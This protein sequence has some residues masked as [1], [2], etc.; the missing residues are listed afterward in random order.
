MSSP[1]YFLAV[2][3]DPTPPEK[4]TVESGIY[5]PD[6][7]YAPF[8][9][10]R[11]DIVLLY[12]TGS[13]SKYPMQA[14][15]LGIVLHTNDEIVQYRYLPLSQPILKDRIERKFQPSDAEK[16]GNRRFSSFWLFEILRESFV[17]AL[18]DRA[19]VWP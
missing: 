8:P 5:H 2:F 12:C 4:D 7:R 15:G 6:P 1:K 10:K 3:G 17:G 9:T 14:P 13:Y 18:G 19:L 11:G 16:F